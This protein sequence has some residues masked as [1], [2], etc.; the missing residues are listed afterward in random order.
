MSLIPPVKARP[1]RRPVSA[2][3]WVLRLL[4]WPLLMLVSL[5]VVAW[6]VLHWAILPHIEQ[7]RP[8]IE[9]RASA[10]LGVPVKIGGIEVRSSGWVPAIAL[11]DVVL[12]DPQGRPALSLPHVATALSPHSLLALEPRFEQLLVEGAHLEVRRQA[13]GRIFVAGLDLSGPG[14]SDTDAADWVVKQHEIVIRGASL[15]WTDERRNAPALALTDVQLVMRNGL[16]RHDIRLDATPPPEWGDRFSVQGRFTQSL[17]ARSSDWLRWSGPVHV[18]LPRA[19]LRELRRHVSLPFELSEG[20]GALR[21]W[22]ELRDGQLHDGTAD[23]AM[24]AV[25]LRLAA[26][27]APLTLEQ[28]EGRVVGRRTEAGLTLSLQ[29]FSFLTGSGLRW[30]SGDLNLNLRQRPDQAST[31]G[32]FGASRL[33][34]GLM[35]E[36]AASLPLGD[37]L[38]RLL[39]EVKP[40]GVLSELSLQWDGPLD[41]PAHY[42]VKGSLSGLSLASRAD[43]RTD[44]VGRPGLRNAS[45]QLLANQ[46]GGSAQI[47]VIGGAVELPGVFEDPLLPLD[48]LSAQVHWKRVADRIS[49]QVKDARFANR[50][51]QGE[52]TALWN[53][54]AGTGV[55]RGGRLPGQ[56]ELDGKLAKAVATRTAR[57]LPLGIPEP[58]RRYVEHAVKGGALSNVSFRVKGDLWDFPFRAPA[59]K[60]ELRIAAQLDDVTFA[61]VPAMPATATQPAQTSPWP[62]LTRVSGE[63]VLDR[64]ALEFRNAQAQLGGLQW[65][66]LQGGIPNLAD[67]P[68]LS[69]D[70]HAQGPLAEMLRLVNATPVGG[71]IGEALARSTGAGPADLQ[72]GLAIPLRNV[73]STAVKGSL[74]L[75]GNDVRITPDTPLLAG[76]RG[77][78]DFDEHGFAIVGAA[79]R[80]YGGEL[81]FEGGTQRNAGAG[82]ASIRFTGQG[83]TTAEALRRATELGIVSRLASYMKGQAAYRLDLG[84]V[85]GHP[86][87][88]VTSNLVGM[89]SELP[90]PLGKAAE[91]SLALRYQ[92]SPARDSLGAGQVL[93]DTL[94]VDLG[95]LLQAQYQRELSNGSTRVLR[96]GVGVGEPAPTPATGVAVAINLPSLNVDLWRGVYDKL[97]DE[98]RAPTGGATAA[99]A[100]KPADDADS[101]AYAPATLTVR[102]Q[103]ML[104]LSRRLSKVEARIAQDKPGP[105]LDQA[106]WRADIVADQLAGKVEYRAPQPRAAPG[107]AA[108]GRVYARLSRLSL[109]RSEVDEVES[110]LQ[111]Q[112]STAPALDIVIDDFELRGK[113]LGRLEIEAAN[114]VYTEG[115]AGARTDGRDALREWRLA[116][117]NLLTPEAQLTAS[118]QWAIGLPGSTGRRAV[119]DFKLALADSGDYLQRLGMGRVVRGGKGQISGQLAWQGSPL[120]IDYASLSGHAHVEVQ[121]G[122]FL[123]VDPGAARLLGVLS[124]QSLPRRL[125]LDFR[126]LFDEGFSFDSFAGDLKIT[127]GVAHTNNLRMRGVQA[128]V[129]MEGQ[130]DLARETQDLRVVVVPEINA[131][132]ASLAYAII[133]PAVGLGTFLAQMFLRRPFM[134]ANTRE[135]HVTGPWGD[136]KVDR[137]ERAAD[138]AMP[139]LDPPEPAASTP[140]QGR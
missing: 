49:V 40:Q 131:G 43:P 116:K 84:F 93:R 118:G 77:R 38:R 22:L 47:G 45:V 137:V 74:Q 114:R 26:N 35:A 103:D 57:Y 115:S 70:G 13:D 67:Q 71:W 8:Q 106:Q 89:V 5:L 25:S 113:R 7:W 60:G 105:A 18:E 6:L 130:A 27:V 95:G 64:T 81:A 15:R 20:I 121:G 120:T 37:A 2:W 4:L 30:Q 68:M 58:T 53:T 59:S 139:D 76:A 101:A 86:E 39:A 51:A 102:A 16:R 24:R 23:V 28:L 119:M 11:R 33:D 65:S 34:L 110:L 109:P 100:A 10:V 98:A 97:F 80:A 1:S 94:R 72:L 136:P 87:L 46:D 79:A 12:L 88:T 83:S 32:D 91:S 75:A 19:D 17:L 124:L 112:P 62:A 54:G 31:G 69:L 96:G 9:A 55:A 138:A 73:A 126:D 104:F 140:I 117:F 48:R 99:L 134:Q 21:A 133:N 14:G 78:V 66:R 82:D 90:A 123:K 41:A 50:D 132:T 107:P 61:Y 108:G 42:Q 29:R 135:F 44:A 36:V 52:F 122:Q 56:I 111:E 63:L 85:K 3:G 128:A 92:T 125:A 127:Q 129:L